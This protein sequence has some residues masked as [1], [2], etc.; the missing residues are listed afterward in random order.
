[1]RN[2]DDDQRQEN[3]LGCN[4]GS[5]RRILARLLSKVAQVLLAAADSIVLWAR[6]ACSVAT[7]KVVVKRSA[8]R[9]YNVSW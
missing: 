9:T 8:V 3:V 1:M 7:T 4:R 2:G 6:L 5:A